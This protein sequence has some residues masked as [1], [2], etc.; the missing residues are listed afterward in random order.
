MDVSMISV[1]DK[2]DL[3]LNIYPYHYLSYACQP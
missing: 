1:L 3:C 2:E